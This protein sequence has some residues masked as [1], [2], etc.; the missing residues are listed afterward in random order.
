MESPVRKISTGVPGLDKLLGGGVETG[1][2]TQFF[3][4]AG[5]GKSNLCLLC[6]KEILSHGLGAVWIDSEGFSVERFIQIA[7]DDA[8]EY[9]KRLY[10][11]EPMSFAEQGHYIF[12]SQKLMKSGAAS[13]IILD[14]ATALY[15]VEQ[16]ERKNAQSLL[17]Q[18]MITLLGISKRFEIPALITNQVF[19][20]VDSKRL[21]GLGGNALSHISKAIIR[22]DK[23]DGFRR[24]VIFKH[25]SQPEGR[26]W[27]FVITGDG[28]RDK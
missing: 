4:E 21:N 28:V 11:F 3:G 25:R 17:S 13:I 19:M 1:M 14:S 22:I 26:I 16:A 8:E 20:D 23:Y 27:D 18:Q 15:R 9:M 12:E 6:A 24:A 10:V 5:C 7:G 2:I